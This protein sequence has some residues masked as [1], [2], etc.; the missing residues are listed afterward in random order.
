MRKRLHHFAARGDESKCVWQRENTGQAGSHIFP[1]AMAD[2]GG[3]LDAPAHPQ[4]SQRIFNHEHRRLSDG[5]L[6]QV[7]I[8]G[9]ARRVNH[10]PQILTQVRLEQPAAFIYGFLEYRL[11][12]VN[13]PAHIHP[14]RALPRKHENYRRALRSRRAT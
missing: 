9:R 1:E 13:F 6:S 7:G 3:G 8:G 10:R 14:L 4:F 12:F 2:H 11:G 5:S